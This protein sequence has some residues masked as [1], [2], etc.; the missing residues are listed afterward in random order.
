MP[1]YTIPVDV[2]VLASS[3]AGP[4]SR[5]RHQREWASVET[6]FVS[7]KYLRGREGAFTREIHATATHAVEMP[8]S[9]RVSPRARLKLNSSR[10]LNILASENVNEQGKVLRLVCVEEVT[11]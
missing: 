4:D 10:Y 3:T 8:Y 7:M 1:N 6:G 11:T 2:E 9:S 5:G